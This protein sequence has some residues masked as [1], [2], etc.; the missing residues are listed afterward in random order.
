V[1]HRSLFTG[2]GGFDLAAQWAGIENVFQ[3]E[4]N[5][6]CLRLL[7]GKFPLVN[8]FT[9]VKKVGLMNLPKVDVL[10]GGFPC[11]DISIINLKGKGLEGKRSGLWFEYF[12]IINELRPPFIIIENV[13]N[14]VNK[15]LPIILGAL[16]EIG[17]NIEWQVIQASEMGARH[18]RAR[19][20]VVAYSNRFGWL[21]IFEKF[22]NCF[23]EEKN[24]KKPG[25]W[26]LL[27]HVFSRNDKMHNWQ[28]FE[29]LICRDDDGLPRKLD[30]YRL[31]GLD[32]A[33]V[34]QIAYILFLIIKEAF[35]ASN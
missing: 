28:K 20:W 13:R 7:E 16:S 15:G 29:N 11:Q 24:K 22:Q 23:I 17:Y 31:S 14:L 26:E 9:N 19:L 3:V 34:P 27:Q 2:I 18:K 4:N 8:R 32:N 10:T 5:E 12:R 25:E 30:E 1:T 35:N 6:F 33:I 21:K